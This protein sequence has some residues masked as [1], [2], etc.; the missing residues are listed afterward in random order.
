M[1]RGIFHII[2]H[3]PTETRSTH[4][5]LI[6]FRSLLN[7]ITHLAGI[8]FKLERVIF[9]LTCDSA[10]SIVCVTTQHERT[11]VEHITLRIPEHDLR[12]VEQI[13]VKLEK[14]SGIPVNRADVLRL[15]LNKGIEQQL[16][17][18]ARKG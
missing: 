7:T 18:L 17:E 14:V 11:Q 13:R 16:K 4:S 6:L 8:D 5:D 15:L 10:C 9:R 1:H 2:K 12:Q 3:R